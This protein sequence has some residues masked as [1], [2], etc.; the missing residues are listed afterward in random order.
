MIKGSS[1]KELVD[2]KDSRGP[3]F[4][5]K[6]NGIYDKDSS[7]RLKKLQKA[8]DARQQGIITVFRS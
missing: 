3:G 1:P 5:V 7:E 4:P 6:V 8:M 2:D